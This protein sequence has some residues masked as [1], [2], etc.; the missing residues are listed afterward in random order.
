MEYRCPECGKTLQV[1]I[2][3]LELHGGVVVCPQCLTEFHTVLDEY[4]TPQLSGL[5]RGRKVIPEHLTYS[6]CHQCGHKIPEGVHF[7][8]YCG[9]S[10]RVVSAEDVILSQQPDDEPVVEETPLT[11]DTPASKAADSMKSAVSDDGD[12]KTLGSTRVWKPVLPSYRY[13]AKQARTRDKAS[14]GFCLMALVVIIALLAVLAFILFKV[15][16]LRYMN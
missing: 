2:E 16:Q 10:L 4:D 14:H 1:S 13:L 3:E 8:P 6:Y 5:H 9:H 11:T 12:R 7:C 15:Y